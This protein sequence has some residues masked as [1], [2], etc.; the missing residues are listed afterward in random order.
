MRAPGT[1]TG[2][3]SS[4][5]HLAANEGGPVRRDSPRPQLRV[6]PRHLGIVDRPHVKFLDAGPPQLVY[7]PRVE[8]LRQRNRT[9]AGGS[10][11]LDRG[12]DLVRRRSPAAILIAL[13][14]AQPMPLD[15]R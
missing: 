12:N 3:V 7:E 6:E 11:S 10:Q 13:V 5:L 14:T 9:E 8:M 1:T 2:P 15:I 4:P